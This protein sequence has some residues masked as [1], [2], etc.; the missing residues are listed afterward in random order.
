MVPVRSPSSLLPSLLHPAMPLPARLTITL[1]TVTADSWAASSVACPEPATCPPTCH[2]DSK[3]SPL[4]FIT[5]GPLLCLL[6]NSVARAP[7]D[8][9]V[10]L[11]VGTKLQLHHCH[12][13]PLSHPHLLP[14]LLRSLSLGLTSPLA[15]LIPSAHQTSSING[16]MPF[17]SPLSNLSPPFTPRCS[18][19]LRN[20]PSNGSSPSLYTGCVCTHLCPLAVHTLLQS[21][22]AG[23]QMSRCHQH[24]EGSAGTEGTARLGSRGLPACLVNQTKP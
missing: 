17:S 10:A 6:M 22:G 19:L 16:L 5:P 15:S 21:P 20:L 2:K 9:E 14:P 24:R 13:L 11:G 23:E 7:S 3:T 12:L 8:L 1:V 18:N 4:P